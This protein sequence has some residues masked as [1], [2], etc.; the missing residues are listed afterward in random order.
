MNTFIVDHG[1]G[2]GLG[3]ALPVDIIVESLKHFQK[4]K[5]VIR[6]YVGLKIYQGRIDEF[7]E[8]TKK[9]LIKRNY[10]STCV[11]ILL[12]ASSNCPAAKASLHPGDIILKINNNKIR[13]SGQVI[14]YLQ[15]RVLIYILYRILKILYLKY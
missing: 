8:E 5:K 2:E 15:F 7:S 10:L 13:H 14:E 3:F 6:P 4:Y 1:L 11:S 12:I 9:V